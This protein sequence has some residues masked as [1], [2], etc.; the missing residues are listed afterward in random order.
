MNTTFNLTRR[1]LLGAGVAVSFL[2]APAFAAAPSNKK[3]V[4][5]I[6]RGGFDGL[7]V[8]VPLT[9]KNYAPMR[10]SLAI[11]ASATLK[12]DTDFGL[13]PKLKNVAAMAADGQVKIAPAI[14]LP[15]H[16]RSHFEAQDLLEEGGPKLY[17]VK[18]GWLNR[19]LR[20]GGGKITQGIA[21]MPQAP[22]AL[23]G[24]LQTMSWSPGDKAA[25][26]SPR[27]IATVQ[28]LFKTDPMLGS[29]FKSGL[30]T[31][32]LGKVVT[33]GNEGDPED[34]KGFASNAG[35]FLLVEGGPQIAVLSI[36]GFDTHSTQG[37]VEGQLAG[38]L[39]ILDDMVGALKASLGPAWKDTVVMV[40]TEFGRTAR[41]NGTE[42]LDHGTAGT[43]ILAGGAVKG[44]G[45][46]GDYPTLAENK[47]FENRDLAPTMDIRSAYKG[48]LIDHLGLDRSDVENKVFA[49]SPEA[50]AAKGMIA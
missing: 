10:G 11:P 30:E 26:P 39:K 41:V 5:I 14:A 12:Y 24:E 35:K 42:G 48:V 6:C 20:A 32:A 36:D 33:G 49:N 46:I 37:G 34:L 40:A 2:S 44:G 29:A 21:V 17:A 25:A 45:I 9:D 18:D 8:S 3:F 31:E 22:I 16:I 23:R 43:M 1:G 28:D 15:E 4:F 13:H 50:P 19:A 38:R 7:A 27:L 47:L